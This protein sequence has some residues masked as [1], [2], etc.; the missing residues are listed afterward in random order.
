MEMIF[1]EL[2]PT[3]QYSYLKPLHKKAPVNFNVHTDD[4]GYIVLSVVSCHIRTKN[5]LIKIRDFFLQEC[6]ID[7]INHSVDKCN[8][9][10]WFQRAECRHHASKYL[11]F[12]NII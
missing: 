12:F 1:T 5:D 11:I 4:D 10:Y 8:A 2:T 6:G 9:G 7:N 3:E